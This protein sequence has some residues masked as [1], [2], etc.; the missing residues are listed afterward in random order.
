MFKLFI[1]NLKMMV[2][3][4]QAL[5]WSLAF[6]LMFTVIF[7]FFFGSGN[8]SAGSVA[9]I[10]NAKTELSKNYEK[11]LND[12]NV[13]K[14]KTDLSEDQARD[15]LSKNQIGAI[16][17][18]PENF[19][20]Q[21]EN[22]PKS[23][24]LIEDPANAQVNSV[25]DGFSGQFFTQ[26]DFQ[27]YKIKPTYSYDI[28]KTNQRKLSYFDFVL[29]GL[30]GLA[31]MNASI[32]GIAITMANY[33]EDKILKRIT[34]TPLPTWKFIG[35]EV[36]SRLILNIVQVTLILGI[37]IYGFHANIYGSYLE[38]YAFALI[39]GLLFQ[40]LGFLIASVSKTTDSAQGMAMSISIPMMFL[41]GVFFPIDQ[42]P[43]WLFTIVQYLPLAPLLR[44]IRTIGLEAGNPFSNPLNIEIVIGWII[45]A[46][47]FSVWRFKLS[48]E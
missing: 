43:K 40:S 4:R 42:L 39:G 26:I 25:L 28:E 18:V 35:A 29:M 30:I 19:G 15:Q 10:D 5:F 13:L 46:I 23:I 24:K 3:G 32:Q 48:D 47:A 33:R 27:I 14:V 20:T 2:R 21:N 31:L 45:I 16:V 9:L 44:M 11:A 37:G 38:L 8:T 7:G 1:S 6:P 36:L 41:A 34:T 17:V 12:S 22:S